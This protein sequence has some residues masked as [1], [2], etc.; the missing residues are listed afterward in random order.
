MNMNEYLDFV[1]RRNGHE[2]EFLHAAARTSAAAAC[3]AAPDLGPACRVMCYGAC[4]QGDEECAPAPALRCCKRAP[5][6]DYESVPGDL[7]FGRGVASQTFRVPLVN[8]G[9]FEPN[10]TVVASLSIPQDLTTPGKAGSIR[11]GDTR[12]M[13]SLRF[14]ARCLK[15]L[16]RDV[17]SPIVAGRWLEGFD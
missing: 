4:C 11:L 9:I 6:V 1:K 15:Q 10:R 12:D 13:A 17:L 5:G 16:H 8:D 7:T 3:P 14:T 2:P